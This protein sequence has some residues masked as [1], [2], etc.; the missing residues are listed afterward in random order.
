MEDFEASDL[1][2]MAPRRHPETIGIKSV[3][4][5]TETVPDRFRA[6]DLWK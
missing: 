1:L 6:V 3:A 4:E 5:L 2:K